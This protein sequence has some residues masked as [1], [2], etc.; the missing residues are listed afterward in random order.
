MVKID[1]NNIKECYI[2]WNRITEPND[3]IAKT[4]INNMGIQ[5]L[6]EMFLNNNLSKWSNNKKLKT[7]IERWKFRCNLV[8]IDSVFKTAKKLNAYLIYPEHNFWPKQLND[9]QI[10]APICFWV[11]TLNIEQFAKKIA[12]KN[13]VL[14]VVGS[15]SISTY[16]KDACYNIIGNIC[17]KKKLTIVSG[18]AYGIDSLAHKIAL[19]NGT[20]TVSVMAGGVDNLYPK[21]NLDLLRDIRNKGAIISEC[22]F[23]ADPRKER[24]LKRNRLIATFST[25]TVIVEAPFRSGALN[26]ASNAALIGRD[27]GVVPGNID[28]PYSSGCNRL[29][30]DGV[31]I[32]IRSAD[33]LLEFFN[34]YKA[35]ISNNELDLQNTDICEDLDYKEKVIYDVLYVQKPLSLERIVL[36][37]GFT[38]MEVAGKLGNLI[39]K[40]IVHEKNGGYCK[41]KL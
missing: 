40:G 30:R 41:L 4:L 2:L 13:N 11:R 9:L 5:K 15:R 33:D 35:S 12:D 29:I 36:E 18:G 1:I 8:N 22:F 26:T 39:Q 7:N 17:N 25:A 20:Y 3:I 31:G 27:V 23:G 32:L 24:F 14:S 37:T 34:D 16:G 10:N 6:T 19:D 38:I 28:S 21:Q